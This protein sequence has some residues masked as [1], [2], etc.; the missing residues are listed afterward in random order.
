MGNSTLGGGQDR[1]RRR[2]A[3]E[4]PFPG[5]NTGQEALTAVGILTGRG[6]DSQDAFAALSEVGGPER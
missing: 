2:G 5:R 1:L 4:M 6:S 3:P